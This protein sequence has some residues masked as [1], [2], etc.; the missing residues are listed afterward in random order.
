MVRL[1]LRLRLDVDIEDLGI[2]LDA[3]PKQTSFGNG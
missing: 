2:E 3:I 1:F